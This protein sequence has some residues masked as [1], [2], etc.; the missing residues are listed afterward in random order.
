[1]LRN[2]NLT[3]IPDSLHLSYPTGCSVEQIVIQQVPKF[4]QDKRYII[5]ADLWDLLDSVSKAGLIMHELFFREMIET[6][7]RNP[8]LN[9]QLDSVDLRYLNS[10]ISSDVFET[11]NRD[12]FY[13]LMKS[14]RFFHYYELNLLPDLYFIYEA[15]LPKTIYEYFINTY[16]SKDWWKNSS[17]VELPGVTINKRSPT[18]LD[19]NT[20]NG[21]NIKGD[22]ISY[23][24]VNGHHVIHG[25]NINENGIFIN[26][27]NIQ[28]GWFEVKLSQCS[29]KNTGKDLNKVF[30]PLFPLQVDNILGNMNTGKCIEYYLESLPVKYNSE[31]G[32]IQK[33]GNVNYNQD[34]LPEKSF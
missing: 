11:M 6:Q 34:G 17:S 18:R 13:E 12:D 8:T 10:L 30:A 20:R 3:N 4:S 21:L 7:V 16:P 24:N 27:L 22:N 31:T 1:M 15:N 32:Y 23:T 33:I 9:E 19:I 26:N 5:N 14:L 29:K 25:N 28:A 2:T